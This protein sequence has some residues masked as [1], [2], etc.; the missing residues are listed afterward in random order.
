MPP[1]NG[2]VKVDGKTFFLMFK[3]NKPKGQKKNL[4][5]Y[6]FHRNKIM[7]SGRDLLLNFIMRTYKNSNTKAIN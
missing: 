2:E 7:N 6:S 1:A 3:L 5:I 4:P